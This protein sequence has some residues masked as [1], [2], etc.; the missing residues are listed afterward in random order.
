[1]VM[2]VQRI[3]TP[4]DKIE[5]NMELDVGLVTSVFISILLTGTEFGAG[6]VAD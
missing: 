1:M 5:A 6:P 4:Y 2:R 3:N